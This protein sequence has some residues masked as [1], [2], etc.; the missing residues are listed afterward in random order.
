MVVPR[1]WVSLRDAI[2]IEEQKLPWK[3]KWEKQNLAVS[4][5]SKA[6][7]FLKGASRAGEKS[8]PGYVGLGF[9]GY[10]AL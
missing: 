6:L 9:F 2:N 8:A 1:L 3:G 7:L 10:S 4:S 5:V